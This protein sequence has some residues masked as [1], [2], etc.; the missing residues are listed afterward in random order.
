[1]KKY[2]FFPVLIGFA[3]LFTTH[4]TLA[5]RVLFIS[6]TGNDAW[7]GQLA[8]PS[9]D[10]SDGPLASLAAAQSI[11]R[12]WIADQS[13]PREDII[14]SL[15]EGIY[16]LSETLELGMHDSG[17]GPAP[18]TWQAFPG[19]VVTLHG[20][21]RLSGFKRLDK[22]GLESRIPTE[23]QGK[24]FVINL[25]QLEAD[26]PSK[27]ARRVWY[28]L[29]KPGPLEL[30]Y[31]DEL[32]TPARYPNK[33]W[34]TVTDVPQDDG[35]PVI[36][37]HHADK[38]VGKVPTGRHYG[39][40]TYED[41]RPETWS[42]ISNVWLHGYWTW[43]WAESTQRIESIDPSTRR[44][45]IAPPHHRYGYTTGQRYYY[46]NIPE[47]LDSP[48]EWYLDRESGY[49]FFWPPDEDFSGEV[50]LSRF[51]K[52]AVRIDEASN[53]TIRGLTFAYSRGPGI[54]IT[55]SE[56]VTIEDCR[57]HSLGG[58]PVTIEGGRNCGVTGGE[59][60]E[61]ST[62]AILIDGGNRKTLEPSN[63]FI[64]NNHVHD[65][66][67]VYRTN[68][69]G[70]RFFGVGQRVAHNLLH[71]APHI[72]MLF[73]GNDHLI[74]YNEIHDIAKETGDVGAIYIGRDYTSRGSIIRYN[75]LHHLH[76]PGLHGV[77]AVYLDDFSSGIVVFGNVFYKAGRAAFIGG[78]RN[79]R[80]QN[81]L[82]IECEPSVQVD[83]RGLS[84]ANHHFDEDHSHYATTLRD[85]MA[86]ANV[87]EPPY[88][89]RYPELQELYADEPKV[90]KYN[91]IENNISF[92][93]TFLDLFDGIDTDL[94]TVR[95]N[96]IAD[97]VVLRMSPT[98]DQDPQFSIFTRESTAAR[99]Y[100]SGNS[101]LLEDPPSLGSGED[102]LNL[103][104]GRLAEGIGFIPIPVSKIGL[105]R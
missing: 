95:N 21:T 4:V 26:Y 11:V 97:P 87:T 36:E 1:M 23:F 17:I 50:V 49:L 62:G 78:G 2:P 100:L 70:I 13:R 96:L 82:F 58:R 44:I 77:R 18:V 8:E 93:G 45:N 12:A 37:G 54:W 64:I 25:K 59:F 29:D 69:P 53:L 51:D 15:R 92:G 65:F 32:M 99:K 31:E 3:L 5:T 41:P 71:D 46:F 91:I 42:D 24:V 67:K 104:F 57:F 89:T 56:H 34:V 33:G 9:P 68:H 10:H 79:N 85:F 52:P 30:Y 7:S 76:G 102:V 20:G 66:S 16:P 55:D 22:T 14:I 75:Y 28:D 61:L 84:W 47:E 83:G 38:R 90:P 94:V 60:T 81:N 80:I 6:P 72:A 105:L 39:A 27:V 43:D 86:A 63:H 74:E 19:E 35:E 98:S 88:S 73:K 40:I 101:L 48:G 103:D